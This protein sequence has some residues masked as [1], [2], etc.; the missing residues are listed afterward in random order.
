MNKNS[1]LQYCC[2]CRCYA[3]EACLLVGAS[4]LRKRART[5]QL[6]DTN[7][8]RCVVLDGFIMLQ[9]PS[10]GTVKQHQQSCV[11]TH[12]EFNVISV[13]SCVSWEHCSHPW[14]YH[15]CLLH[16]YYAHVGGHLRWGGNLCRSECRKWWELARTG[17]VIINVPVLYVRTT[18]STS[19]CA[20]RGSFSEGASQV[21]KLQIEDPRS[22]AL[23][24]TSIGHVLFE[25]PRSH[26][27]ASRS[28]QH[29]ALQEFRTMFKARAGTPEFG[30]M[31]VFE[32]L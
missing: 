20:S 4:E 14:E 7:P 9:G 17:S 22:E 12:D 23:R 11:L 26:S 3:A 21:A 24:T 27:A 31:Q 13:A 19:S 29:N 25:N 8:P 32:E 5:A 18:I 6:L 1:A 28:Y 10:D 15:I 2:S 16:L 30:K